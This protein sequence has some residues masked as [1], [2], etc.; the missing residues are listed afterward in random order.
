MFL[1]ELGFVQVLFN[2]YYNNIFL[3]QD[4]FKNIKHFHLLLF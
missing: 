3:F 1:N 4:F 2:F